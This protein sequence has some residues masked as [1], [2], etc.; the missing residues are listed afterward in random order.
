[1]TS[2][3]PIPLLYSFTKNDWA[4]LTDDFCCA[5]FLTDCTGSSVRKLLPMLTIG[6][7]FHWRRREYFFVTVVVVCTY[8]QLFHYVFSFH[9]LRCCNSIVT[10]SFYSF[11]ISNWKIHQQLITGKKSYK[12]SV[13]I[14]F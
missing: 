3:P 7:S 2:T 5:V 4:R 1:M 13:L 12:T 14:V 11:D 8:I 9:I 6:L 10:H